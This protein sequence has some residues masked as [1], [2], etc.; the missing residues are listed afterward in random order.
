M[1]RGLEGRCLRLLHGC[2]E[3][4]ADFVQRLRQFDY[5]GGKHYLSNRV[6]SLILPAD[7]DSTSLQRVF[8]T[9]QHENLPRRVDAE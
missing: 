6:L 7:G 3:E 4:I 8:G 5:L 1:P 9:I 2:I